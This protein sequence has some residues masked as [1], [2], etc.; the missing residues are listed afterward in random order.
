MVNHFLKKKPHGRRRG[1]ATPAAV[2]VAAIEVKSEEDGGAEVDER[3]WKQVTGD[4]GLQVLSLRS[5]IVYHAC[6]RGR[7]SLHFAPPRLRIRRRGAR[8]ATP[9]AS[10]PNLRIP[11]S[12]RNAEQVQP[13]PR[14]SVTGLPVPPPLGIPNLPFGIPQSKW[15]ARANSPAQLSF[16]QEVAA[17]SRRWQEDIGRLRQAYAMRTEPVRGQWHTLNDKAKS[18][19]RDLWMQHLELERVV[20]ARHEAKIA[21]LRESH[22]RLREQQISE[23]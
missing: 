16:V 8:A 4:V 11:I 19:H 18:E 1:A 23:C 22:R 21:S 12:C 15:E 3:Q 6:H 9:S 2:A 13:H 10:C 7:A 17:M 20:S 14:S 5:V